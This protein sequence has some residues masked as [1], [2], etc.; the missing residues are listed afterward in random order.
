AAFGVQSRV[1]RRWTLDE[2]MLVQEIADRTWMTLEHRK[3]DAEL[4]A[5]E[6]RLAFL[7]RLN[8]ALRP[9]SD[10]GD[11]QE[12]AARLAGEHLGVRRAGYAE[13][14]GRGEYVTRREYTRGVA[15][16]VGQSAAISIGA[17]LR[18]AFRRGETVAVSDM[19][20]DPRLQDDERATMRAQQIVAFVGV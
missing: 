16:L 13:V 6:E 19:R 14:R 8:D 12:I 7:L 15:P 10:P 4:R 17:Q 18:E 11:V 9:L 2:V 20:T 5:N 1:P 3:A